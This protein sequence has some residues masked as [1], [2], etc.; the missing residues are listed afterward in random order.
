MSDSLSLVKTQ[1][2]ENEQFEEIQQSLIF[3]KYSQ[4]LTNLLYRL[5]GKYLSFP[6]FIQDWKKVKKNEKICICSLCFLPII[7]KEEE[8]EIESK[9]YH[10]LCGNFWNHLTINKK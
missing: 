10:L 9:S 7:E 6:D 5:N 4:K 8:V 2:D 1:L 3:T